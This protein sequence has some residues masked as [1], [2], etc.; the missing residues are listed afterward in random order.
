[1]T[2]KKGVTLIEMLVV[3]LILAILFAFAVPQ[4]HKWQRQYSI[5]SDTKEIYGI[6]QKE[7]TKAFTQKITVD[8]T[9]NGKKVTINENGSQTDSL[10]LH[11]RFLG[12]PITIDT[13]GTLSGSSVYYDSSSAVGLNPQY[14]CVVVNDIRVKLGEWNGS[15]C[16]PQ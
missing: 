13:R 10:N 3:I 4:Y 14:D 2:G 11:N 1:M 6:V 15:N 12:G 8:I 5:E 16:E 7:R 9:F